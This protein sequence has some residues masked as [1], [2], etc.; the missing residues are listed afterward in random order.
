M[1]YGTRYSLKEIMYF[2]EIYIFSDWEGS[3]NV[4]C[5]QNLTKHIKF[6]ITQH[7]DGSPQNFHA[8]SPYQMFMCYCVDIGFYGNYC[9]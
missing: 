3:D 6:T 1:L 4:A 7:W 5:M 8:K 2:K 9:R